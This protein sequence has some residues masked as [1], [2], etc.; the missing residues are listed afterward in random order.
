MKRAAGV[1]VNI[2]SFPGEF[3]IGGFSKDGEYLVSMISKMGFS[4]LQ[5]LPITAIGEGNSPYSGVSS[6]AGN[7]L[8][9]NPHRLLAAGLLTADEVRAARYSG[10]HFLADYDF[11]R[12]NTRQLL[13]TA[14][15]RITEEIREEMSAF[16]AEN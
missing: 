13:K 5:V 3:G 14:S 6:F 1:L 2:S 11:A 16:L 4:W 15:G 12:A 10:S 8:Y 9:I 7:S